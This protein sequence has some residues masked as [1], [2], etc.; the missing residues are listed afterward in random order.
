MDVNSLPVFSK[1]ELAQRNGKAMA[2]IWVAYKGAIYDVSSSELFAGGKHYEHQAGQDLTIEM[3]DAPHLDDVMCKFPMVGTLSGT[4]YAP[5]THQTSSESEAP[6]VSNDFSS[7][8]TYSQEAEV[9]SY[10]S[11][12]S[13]PITTSPS[14]PSTSYSSSDAISNS[15]SNSP[16][17]RVV[18]MKNL[19][20]DIRKIRFEYDKNTFT[21]KAGQYLKVDFGETIG[22][23]S[24]SIATHPT[25]DFL[26]LI[27]QNKPGGKASEYLFNDLFPG[28]ELSIS[29]PYSDFVLPHDTN[30]SLCFICTDVGIAPIRSLLIDIVQQKKNYNQ[31]D[32]VYGNRFAADLLFEEELKLFTELIPEL[33]CHFAYSRETYISR[34]ITKG[35]VHSVYEH[36]YASR[37]P[38]TFF[39]CGWERMVKEAKEKI[40]ALGYD[41]EKIKTQLYI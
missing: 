37:I 6:K 24:Y 7:P 41:K 19:T 39:V 3:G 15:S 30:Q 29:G 23:R 8:I 16:V 12:F 32:L 4:T 20:A 38:A 18:E 11:S 26:D 2:Q 5:P 13:Q 10:T 1:D 21:F 14:S 31:I 28:D 35:Y 22:K 33:T 40:A 34:G 17:I 9:S 27:I 25:S 36:I